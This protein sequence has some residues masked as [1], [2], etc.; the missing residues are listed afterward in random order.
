MIGKT[1]GQYTVLGKLGGGGM[2]VVYRAK[3]AKLNRQVALKFLPQ[4]WSHDDTAKQRFIREAQAASATDHPN[5]CTIHDIESTGDGQLFIVMALYEGQTL[6]QRLEA[7]ALPLDEALQ[8]AGEVAEGLVKAHA[9]GIVHRDIKPGNLFLTENGVRILDF[10]LAKFADTQQ[11]TIAGTTVGTVAYMS[12]E[13]T[14]GEDA[15]VRSDVWAVG[16]VLYEMLTGEPPFKGVYTEAILYAI[17]ND[18]PPALKA[19]ERGIPE[20]VERLVLKALHKN[21]A[22]RYQTVRELARD[23]RLL[24]GMSLP[25]ELRTEPI[26]ISAQGAKSAEAPTLAPASRRRRRRALAAAAVSVAVLAGVA[27]WLLLPAPRTLVAVVPVVNQ[28]GYAELDPYRMALT[29]T[30]VAEL[31]EASSLRVLPYERVLQIERQFVNKALDVAG[32]EAVRALTTHSGATFILVPTLL[33]EN[34]AWRARVEVRSA[35]TATN[36]AVYDSDPIVSSLSKDTVYGLMATL[37]EKVQGYFRT[38]G[39]RR[40]YAVYLARRLAGRTS[41]SSSPRFRTLDA[42]KAFEEGTSAYEQL[43]Y[44]AAH[45]SFA[46]VAE[47]DPQSGLALAW[48][49]RVAVLMKQDAEAVRAADQA[50]RLVTHDTR[51]TDTLFISAVGAESHRDFPTAEARY[52]NLAARHTDEPTWLN[53][54]ASF[55]DRIGSTAQ[56]VSTYL[57]ALRLEG[58]LVRPHLELCRLYSPSRLN[59]SADAKSHGESALAAYMALGNQGGEAQARLCLTDLLRLGGPDERRVARRSAE[60]ALKIFQDLGHAYNVPRAYHYVAMAAWAQGQTA[61]A[62]SLWQKSLVSARAARNAF[63][64]PTVLMNL[65]VAHE[66]L[67]SRSRALSYYRECAKLW[68]AQGEQQR[69]AQMQVNEA[70]LLVDSGGAPDEGFREAQ[71]ALAVFQK[72]QDKHY[73][74]FALQVSGAYYRYAGRH[75]AARREL[76]RA[77]AVAG[78]RDLRSNIVSATIELARSRFD[79]GAY[80]EARDLLQQVNAEESSAEGTH[81]R[82]RLS[83]VF[84]RLGDFEAA[85]Q[86]LDKASAELQVRGEIGLLP[87][88]HEVLGELAYEAGRLTEAR[89]EFT[90]AG[91]LSKDDWPDPAAVEARAYLGLLDAMDGRSDGARALVQSSLADAHRL[92]HFSLETRCVLFLARIYASLRRFDDSFNTLSEIGADTTEQAIG[93]ELQAQIHYWRSQA[94]AARRDLAGAQS[95]KNLAQTL[96]D[97]L[98]RSLP[99]Q[100]HLAFASR[101]DIRVITR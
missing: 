101:Q 95:E 21:P 50:S 51:P 26:S 46:S 91:A 40:A 16:V 10:G 79:V 47:Q 52:R 88:L 32:R 99:E 48:L 38:T 81:A 73:E 89:T 54:L 90:K 34:R 75:E 72:L 4:Q 97:T 65:G 25:V 60:T 44:A 19:N 66:A 64:E 18:P 94:L 11:L 35:E 42:A 84:V 53:E 93:P 43:E 3:D 59:E 63:L 76:T 62:E 37:G 67:G 57:A 2:G 39:P 20:P 78:E 58:R 1:L 55:Q 29:Q 61:E 69:A 24:R 17:R 85:R 41:P 27:V 68:E 8:I 70:A 9:Q 49:S 86:G 82:I 12:P 30:L 36:V 80:S 77:L 45:R 5:I 100:Y 14:R 33:Y 92:R 71:N 56:A 7:G 22:E 98:Q 83:R 87:L 74:A 15:D 31:S 6:K 28:T 13:Q 96:I 23:L